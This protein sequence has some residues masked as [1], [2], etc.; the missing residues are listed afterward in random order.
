[1]TGN[2]PIG[3]RQSL[4]PQVQQRQLEG[5]PEDELNFLESVNAYFDHAA[6]L[7]TDL[8][9]GTKKALKECEAVLRVT[10]PFRCEDGSIET[11]TGYRCHHSYHRLPVK[12]GIRYSGE[13]DIQETMAL[14][15]LM[16]WKC[17]VV[18]VPFGGAKGS[19]V[20]DPRQYTP[21]ELE[22]ITR[23]YTLELCQY[24]FIGPGQ[25]VPAP[26]MGTSGREMA[27][28]RDTYAAFN[29]SD[30]NAAGCVTGKPL[31]S[32]GIRGRVEATGLG[33]YYGVRELLNKPEEAAKVG[34]EPGLN[35][36]TVV[37]QGFGN[38]GY[39]A[40]KFFSEAGCKVLAIGEWDCW[41]SNDD[42]IDVIALQEH[43]LAKGTIKGF[44]GATTHTDTPPAT[45][46]EQD[47]DILIPAAMEQQ[48]HRDNAARIKAKVIGEAAN[49][50]TTPA[51]EEILEKNGKA[52]LPDLYLNAGG[53][54]VSYFE[55][56][57][58]LSH[59]RF[60][61]LNR[62]FEERRGRAIADAFEMS[63]GGEIPDEH[64]SEIIR[65]AE[66][67]DL[68][69]SGLEDTMINALDEILYT[70]QKLGCNFRTA[71]YYNAIRKVALVSEQRGDLIYT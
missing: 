62:R 32:G 8:P 53:V 61:R 24:K 71:A 59:V 46:L 43:K 1:M 20:I 2:Y 21:R 40:A 12:G 47:C 51:A 45:C 10:F 19:V 70:S 36:K 5:L 33:V 52:I 17:A 29:R 28:I 49:G 48:L 3:L 60:G 54:V 35:G 15:A 18:D 38:V 39:H 11:I 30:V 50:P 67:G 14:A 9:D 65:G 4:C 55:W 56:L 42:G 26:D 6:S 64:R 44:S 66:E 13:A 37:V 31:E 63:F 34:L 58:N 22:K 68:A 69:W 27:W 23:A 25:D 16:T 7:I 57:K 41:I